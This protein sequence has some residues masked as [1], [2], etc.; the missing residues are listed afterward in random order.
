MTHAFGL[1]VTHTLHA[2]AYAGG[3]LTVLALLGLWLATAWYAVR[4][5]AAVIVHIRI[6]LR[7]RRLHREHARSGRA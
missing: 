6:L 5:W 4:R 1:G 2:L 3:I 7:A